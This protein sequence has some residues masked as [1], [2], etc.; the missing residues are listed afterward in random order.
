MYADLIHFHVKWTKVIVTY[1]IV[2]AVKPQI[3][4]YLDDGQSVVQVFLDFLLLLLLLFPLVIRTV[5]VH[6]KVE[7]DLHAAKS[8]VE[9]AEAHLIET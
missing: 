1:W 9:V 6:P 5:I 2:H 8:V 3:E 7:E 4:H